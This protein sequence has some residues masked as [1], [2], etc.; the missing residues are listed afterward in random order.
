MKKFSLAQKIMVLPHIHIDGDFQ[1]SIGN[2][3]YHRKPTCHPIAGMD[4]FSQYVCTHPAQPLVR[5]GEFSPL[6]DCNGDQA[7]CEVSEKHLKKARAG[8]RRRA[9]FAKKRMDAALDEAQN[10]TALLEKRKPTEP[11]K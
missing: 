6:A 10:I 5:M 11:S 4:G 8:L 7:K 9:T 1:S 3:P 2:C